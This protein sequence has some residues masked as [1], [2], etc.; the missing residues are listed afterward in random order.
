ML[1]WIEAA[2]NAMPMWLYEGIKWYAWVCL[3]GSVIGVS[4]QLLRNWKGAGK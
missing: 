4:W 1:E 3:I 2:W